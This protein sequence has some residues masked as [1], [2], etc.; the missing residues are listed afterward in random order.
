MF[1]KL[2]SFYVNSVLPKLVYR[3]TGLIFYVLTILVF[4]FNPSLIIN[5][6]RTSNKNKKD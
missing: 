6:S 4:F 5:N 1:L 2:M 3:K